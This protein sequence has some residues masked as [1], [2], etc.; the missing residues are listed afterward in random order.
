MGIGITGET[1]VLTEGNLYLPIN[2]LVGTTPSIYYRGQWRPGVEV[3]T[4]GGAAIVYEVCLTNG[5][6]VRAAEDQYW[7]VHVDSTDS[8]GDLVKTKFLQPGTY[9]STGDRE[10]DVNNEIGCLKG[11]SGTHTVYYIDTT[12]YNMYTLENNLLISSLQNV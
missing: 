12:P 5:H 9:I 8:V 10:Y 7:W 6:T 11:V 1:R 4:N 3:V 2:Q